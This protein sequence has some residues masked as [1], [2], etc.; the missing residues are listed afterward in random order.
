MSEYHT[1]VLLRQS[2]DALLTNP[3]GTYVDA[4]FGGGG[5][6][7]EIL[8]RLSMAGRLIAFDRDI[9]S[10]TQKLSDERLILIHDNFRFVENHLL[11][12]YRKG[13]IPSP[14][15]DGILA[16]LGVSSHQFDTPERGFSFRFEGPLD[17]RMDPT[18]SQKTA[19]DIVNTYPVEDL[20]RILRTWGEVPVSRRIAQAI[21]KE[22]ESSPIETTTHLCA[23]VEPLLPKDSHKMLAKVFQALRIEVNGEMRSLEKFLQGTAPSI[24]A[25][26]MLV[27]ITYHSLEDRMVKNYIKSGNTS[28]KEAKDQ[29]GNLIAPFRA[30]IRKPI[31]PSEGEIAAN[32]R[33][34]SAKMRVAQRKE[35]DR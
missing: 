35:D 23:V 8:S 31:E 7:A 6:A 24:K 27:V 12:E 13:S 11:D 21:A 16:D 2:V 22:R 32:P 30:T 33:S 14:K 9:D 29:W 18:A 25:G 15:A 20:E 4:T 10:H 1:P 26:G 5:H 17:M 34:R 3:Q 19:S 28:G